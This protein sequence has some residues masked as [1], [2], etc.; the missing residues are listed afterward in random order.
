MRNLDRDRQKCFVARFVGMVREEDDRGRLTGKNVPGYEP[1]EA[2]YPSV[3]PIRGEAY[4][5]YFGS[6]V[7]YDLTLTVDDPGFRVSETDLLWV[8]ALDGEPGGVLFLE[9]RGGLD[10]G[11]FQPWDGQVADGGSFPTTETREH[12]YVVKRVARKGGFTV[13]AAKHVEVSK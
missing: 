10:G 8:Y 12:D 6:D 5:T 11:S 4:G 1:P 3:S 7:D 2:F 9:N 13:I